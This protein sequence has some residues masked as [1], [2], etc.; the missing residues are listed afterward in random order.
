MLRKP[1]SRSIENYLGFA[2]KELYQ[3]F[4]AVLF[5]IHVWAF[6]QV[7]QD[8]EWISRRT[9]PWDSLGVGGYTLS[10]ALFESLLVFLAVLLISQ[11]IPRKWDTAKRLSIAAAL[12]FMTVIWA[13]LIQVEAIVETTI[14][15][16]IAKFLVSTGRPIWYGAW[17]LMA[18]AVVLYLIIAAPTWVIIRKEK[19]SRVFAGFLDKLAVLSSLYLVMDATGVLLVIY[20]NI[21]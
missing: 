12:Y 8:V 5:P 18:L 19:A 13:I 9:S 15:A 14:R 21:F 6:Y 2:A 17:V 1:L 10:F 16:S 7:F 4:C 20:R 11:L 3:L